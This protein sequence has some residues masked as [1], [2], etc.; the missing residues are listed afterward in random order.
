MS[1]AVSAV[2]FVRDRF[3]W[4]AYLMLAYGTYMVSTIGPLMPFLAA[5]LGL[6]YTVR[7]FHTSA[8]AVGGIIAGVFADRAAHRFGRPRLF[9]IGGGGL[10][11]GALMLI[12]LREPA[13]TISAAFVIG[14]LGTLMFVMVQAGIA[15]HHGE[16]RGIAISESNVGAA[17]AGLLAPLLISQAEGLALGWRVALMLGIGAWAL[18]AVFGR[19]IPVPSQPR[20]PVLH[21]G[22]TRLPR[23]FWL[24][25][26]TMFLG[27]AVEWSVGFWTAEFFERALGVDRVT[28]AGTLSVLWLAIILGR[29]AGSFLSRRFQPSV[30][31][32]G[33]AA[34]A[35][36]GFPV[37]W[38][39]RDPL[40]ATAALFVTGLGIANFFP[41]SLSAAAT[42]AAFNTNAAAAR[43]ALANGL[44][45]LI[46][47]QVLGSAADQMGIASAFGLVGV[48]AGALLALALLANWSQ[49]RHVRRLIITPTP[50]AA[51]R[52]TSG[53]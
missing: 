3:T 46:A 7:G 2:P 29:V 48:L 47:P 5:D 15:D 27:V 37:L 14:L 26:G 45:I 42:A 52:G 40:V 31:L 13:L 12:V 43:I 53:E 22:S 24:F 44:A 18:M 6:S 17:M 28:A 23:L 38:L 8:F 50:A 25:W 9:W 41:M 4:L 11:L 33:A 39:A 21:T 32:I 49:R 34:L 10:A 35:A 19:R 30:L 1:N 20:T 36:A 16:Q 51:P